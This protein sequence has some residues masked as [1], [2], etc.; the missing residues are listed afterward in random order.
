MFL[1]MRRIDT[2]GANLFEQKRQPQPKGND[3]AVSERLST[4]LLGFE[5]GLSMVGTPVNETL[6]GIL[7]YRCSAK[8]CRTVGRQEFTIRPVLRLEGCSIGSLGFQT[9]IYR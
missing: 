9:F 4:D 5:L 2:E 3:V 8:K 6:Q 7:L 1:V